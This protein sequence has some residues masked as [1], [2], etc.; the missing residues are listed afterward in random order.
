MGGV[1]PPLSVKRAM[2]RRRRRDGHTRGDGIGPEAVSGVEADVATLFS[3][4]EIIFS[5]RHFLLDDR[6][7]LADIGFS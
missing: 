3:R 6:P 1:H 5:K 4:L 2:L 7:T